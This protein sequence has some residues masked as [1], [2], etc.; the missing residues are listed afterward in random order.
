VTRT[1]GDTTA[2]DD[3]TFTVRPGVVTGFLGPNTSEL[4]AD[5]SCVDASVFSMLALRRVPTDSYARTRR[6][7]GPDRSA[8]GG[9]IAGLLLSP[10]VRELPLLTETSTDR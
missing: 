3:L 1:F 5:G 8:P 10:T 9:E 2:T 7:A 4:D 6:S